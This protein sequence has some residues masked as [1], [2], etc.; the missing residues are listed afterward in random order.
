MCFGWTL[1]G[2]GVDLHPLSNYLAAARREGSAKAAGLSTDPMSFLAV[3][4]SRLLELVTRGTNQ[5]KR[6]NK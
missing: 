5:I 6:P 2:P 3:R 1:T 4:S